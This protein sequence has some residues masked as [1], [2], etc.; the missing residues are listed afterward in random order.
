[1][2]SLFKLLIILFILM[3]I[4]LFSWKSGLIM[5]WSG[6]IFKLQGQMEEYM[7]YINFSWVI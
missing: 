7:L 2:S 3:R 6:F 1:M 5:I 4:C